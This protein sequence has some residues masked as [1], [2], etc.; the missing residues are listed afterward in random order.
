[1]PAVMNAANEVSVEGF[2]ARRVSFA[3]IPRIIE[4]VMGSHQC[5]RNPGI[6]HLLEADEHAR[7]IAGE[8][9]DKG[10]I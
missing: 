2:L 7:K 3:A 8:I 4:R 1:M 5:V 10:N 9:A 6:E